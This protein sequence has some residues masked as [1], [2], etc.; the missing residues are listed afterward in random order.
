MSDLKVGDVVQ[1]SDMLFTVNSLVGDETN[2]VG[3]DT[4]S[5]LH[6]VNVSKNLLVKIENLGDE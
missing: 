5:N 4:D 1:L 6:S 2:I 3:F